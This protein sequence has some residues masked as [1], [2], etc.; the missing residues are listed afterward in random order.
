MRKVT[1]ELLA[2]KGACPGHLDKFRKRFPTGLDLETV[3]P[4][5]VVG[6][7]VWWAVI[8]MLPAPARKAF[9]EAEDAAWKVYKEAT[10]SAWEADKEPASAWGAY[11][12]ARD[13]A[14]KRH[15]EA[16]ARAA[17]DLFREHWQ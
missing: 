4:E 16:T 10:G 5:E 17:I 2:E 6:L 3:R 7:N 13:A 15:R 9:R 11:G 14:W 8:H 1:A 12:E